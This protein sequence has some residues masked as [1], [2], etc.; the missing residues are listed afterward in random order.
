MV[1]RAIKSEVEERFDRSIPAPGGFGVN[2]RWRGDGETK[3]TKPSSSILKVH[4]VKC[5]KT[6]PTCRHSSPLAV[7]LPSLCLLVPARSSSVDAPVPVSDL[8][9]EHS[10]L[11]RGN[12]L[13]RLHPGM[14]TP[15]LTGGRKSAT[16]R[17]IN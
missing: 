5:R 7:S 1:G 3:E 8:R 2:L 14:T 9:R 6:H 12:R 11:A 13:R 16:R 4:R 17:L 10:P 15:S